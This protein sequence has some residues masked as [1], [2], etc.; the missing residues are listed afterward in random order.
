MEKKRIVFEV[1]FWLNEENPIFNDEGL[2]N[3]K[4]KEETELKSKEAIERT[5]TEL[6][7]DEVY[8]SEVE[9]ITVKIKET[10]GFSLPSKL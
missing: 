10:I 8:P 3:L 1:E 6:F 7:Y 5:L 2:G 4:T 9:K